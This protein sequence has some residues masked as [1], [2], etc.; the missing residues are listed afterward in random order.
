[1]PYFL[2]PPAL[3]G[4]GARGHGNPH[5]PLFCPEANSTVDKR[6]STGIRTASRLRPTVF[7]YNRQG[8]KRF[9]RPLAL[10]AA[11]EL[12]IRSVAASGDG[13][14]AYGGT[15]VASTGE[16]LGFI[17]FLDG[18]GR[19]L[20]ILRLPRF[21]PQ[22]LC[23][24]ADRTLWVAGTRDSDRYRPEEHH[25]VLRAYSGDGT[26]KF[27]QL[28]HSSFAA[29]SRSVVAP[30]SGCRWQNSIRTVR[31]RQGERVSIRHIPGAKF[32]F[33][34]RTDCFM[35]PSQPSKLR[36]SHR[37]CSGVGWSGVD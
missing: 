34:G 19:S 6:I 36:S 35:Y 15:T 31:E 25:D 14:F 2:C 11:H 27:S 33:I 16:R 3:H 18:Q 29:E 9:E 32:D 17:A 28:A 13:R 10:D 12:F 7:A 21:Y 26:L 20:Q 4:A 37:P 8:N 30:P 24:T 23:I 5:R 22:H 1:M